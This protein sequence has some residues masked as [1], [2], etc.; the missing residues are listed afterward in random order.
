MRMKKVLYKLTGN[1]SLELI[2]YALAA[3]I[4]IMINIFSEN[5]DSI[6]DKTAFLSVIIAASVTTLAKGISKL[7]YNRIEDEM[8]LSVD[9]YELNRRYNCSPLMEID[10]HTTIPVIKVVCSSNLS[11]VIEDKPLRSYQLPG[12]VIANYDELFSAHRSSNVYNNVNI[13]VDGWDVGEDGLFVI[14]TS[15]TT[16]FNGL[17]TNRA[18]DYKLNSGLTL[19]EILESGPM[20]NNLENSELSNHL[21]FNGF[22]ETNDNFIIFVSRGKDVSVGKRTLGSSIAASLKT[23]Y[24]LSEDGA[25]TEK[26]LRS[27][28]L[29]EISDELGIPT[30]LLEHESLN[31]FGAYRDLVEGGKPQLIFYY[32]S[33]QTFNEIEAAFKLPQKSK[34]KKKDRTVRDK[35]EY[36]MLKDGNEILAIP[37][38]DLFNNT[39]LSAS[40]FLWNGRTWQI[41]PSTTASIA[42]LKEFL[43][44][45]IR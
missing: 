13:R 25:F 12:I 18:I 23:K 40:S 14:N 9:Y 31:I 33:T 8:K 41:V 17:V 4:I 27:S 15:R 2:I 38:N 20:V 34:I 35:Q 32:K 43:S 26:G 5:M 30:K 22:V 19:R 21:G 45:G 28:I 24:C 3:F 7:I 6:F 16:Y 11:I 44:L 36:K 39:T 1:K 10:G 29:S 37:K 42:L